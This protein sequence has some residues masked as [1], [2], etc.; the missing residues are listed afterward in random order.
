MR[1][2]WQGLVAGATGTTASNAV[3]QLDTAPRGRPPIGVLV[4]AA[5]IGAATGSRST[6]GVAALALSSTPAD[7]GAVVS[8]LGS[9]AGTV[10]SGA[11]AVGE[12]LADK[13]PAAPARTAASGLVPRAALGVSTAAG[14]ARRDGHDPTLAGLVGLG[15]ALGTAVLG[16]HARAAAARRLGSDLPGAITEDVLAATLGWWAT[17]RR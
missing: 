6:A 17:R 15:A 2:S 16:V 5:A 10:V 3:T 13:S 11:L 1:T 14:L 4:R 12:L 9:R 8:R 7:P